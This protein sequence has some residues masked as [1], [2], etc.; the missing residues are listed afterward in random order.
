MRIAILES[1]ADHKSATGVRGSAIKEYLAAKGHDVKVLA[2]DPDDLERF[3]KNRYSLAS[4]ARR[5]LTGRK[6]LPH[7]WDFIADHL[8]PKVRQGRYDVVIGRGQEVA[9]VL[10]R[11]LDC[12]KVLDMANIMFLEGY[13]AWGA[14]LNEVE[15]TY[16]KEMMVFDVVDHILSPHELLTKY[17]LDQFGARD[18]L[19]SKIITARLGCEPAGATAEYS[20]TP[21]IVY[22][23]SY[24]YIQDPY[25]LSWL[26]KISPYTIDCYGPKDPNVGFLPARLNYRGYAANAD[27]L[28]RYQFGLITV[29]RDALRQHSPATKFPYY[30]AHGLPVL[31]PEWMKE[32]HTYPECAIPFDEST[33]VEQ[34]RWALDRDRWRAM[35]G[36]AVERSRDLL[37]EKTLAPLGNLLNGG[38]NKCR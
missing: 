27:F 17:F 30:F 34:V 14:D 19:N 5:R 12:L 28:A 24:Y 13:Y 29:S 4:R 16:R 7:V 21:Q 8:E 11:P 6:T 25:L 31:F 9:Y 35:S 15:E 18:G 20:K 32:G 26:T 33:F 36:A 23:G 1:T 2:P 37:W 3:H 22:A 10:T 38:A